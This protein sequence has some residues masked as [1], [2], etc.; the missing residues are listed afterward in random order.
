M[1]TR[2]AAARQA[3]I[4]SGVTPSSRAL[5]LVALAGG[6]GAEQVPLRHQ[7]RV[8]VV[9]G[10]GAVLV[11]AGDAVDAEVAVDVVVPERAPQARGLDQDVDARCR[12]RTRRR[13]WRATY[14]MTDVGDVGVDVERGGPGRPVAGALLAVDRAPRERR[15]REAEVARARL[16]PRSSVE[17]RQ[18]SASAA[19]LGRGVRE[20]RH[21]EELG[22]PE[23]VAVVAGAG[24]P[25][26]GDRAALG[27]R[28]GGQ[29]LEQREAHRLLQLGIALELDVAAS[30]RSR[31]GRRAARRAAPS[32]PALR[33][34]TSAAATWSR[35][36][37]CV[38]SCDQP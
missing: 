20:H 24:Q 8:E 36:A 32:Q 27:A 3:A 2:S 17:W 7:V 29:D 13:R 12:A 11:G 4:S 14:W 23:R 21:D 33:A 18:R 9:V 26:G 5:V 31:R 15:A 10:D 35:I 22:V 28:A 1:T 25:L 6:G 38:R 19:A 37:G 34:A 30:P 16:A